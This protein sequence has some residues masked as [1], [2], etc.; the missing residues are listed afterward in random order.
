MCMLNFY[1]LEQTILYPILSNM[2]LLAWNDNKNKMFIVMVVEH[3]SFL[4][5]GSFTRH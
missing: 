2:S 4:K 1:G 3:G 5:P